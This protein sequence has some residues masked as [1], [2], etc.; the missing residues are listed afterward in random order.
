M[1]TAV[2]VAKHLETACPCHNKNVVIMQKKVTDITRKKETYNI[3]ESKI[4]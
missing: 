3:L 1:S 2:D 4:N